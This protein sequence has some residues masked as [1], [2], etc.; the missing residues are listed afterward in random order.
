[1]KF[2]QEFL[3]GFVKVYTSNVE[4]RGILA[5]KGWFGDSKESVG[6]LIQAI[7]LL[8]LRR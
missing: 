6:K 1:L 4:R 8:F 3:F 5:D 2:L 7:Y